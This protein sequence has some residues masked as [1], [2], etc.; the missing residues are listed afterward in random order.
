MAHLDDDFEDD[1]PYQVE[2]GLQKSC[3]ECDSQ[4][5]PNAMVCVSCGYHFGRRERVRKTYEPVDSE[6][7]SGPPLGTRVQ[8]FFG[9]ILAWLLLGLP[10]TQFRPHLMLVVGGLWVAVCVIF[11]FLFGTFDH[12]RLTRNR[13]GKTTLVKTWYICFI[14]QKPFK[15]PLSEYDGVTTG[16][17]NESSCLAWIIFFAFLPFIIPAIIWW[18]VAIHMD[19]FYA[20]FTRDQGVPDTTLYRGWSQERAYEI[21]Q[22]VRET[23]GYLRR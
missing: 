12:L 3:P 7:E 1:S 9:C 10:A 13:K 11:G 8:I 21:S 14:P 17:W 20:A 5:D 16:K 23:V 15:I 22:E 18:Y 6:W 2:G 4:L 19:I